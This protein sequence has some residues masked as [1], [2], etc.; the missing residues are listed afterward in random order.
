LHDQPEPTT[1]EQDEVPEDQEAHEAMRGAGH[2]NP[3][4]VED[5]EGE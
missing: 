1:K 3:P 5:L 2:E 4:S